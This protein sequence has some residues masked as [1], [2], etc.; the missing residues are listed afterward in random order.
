MG[1]CVLCR[2]AAEAV[3]TGVTR[4]RWGFSA[5][6]MGPIVD[7]FGP[8]RALGWFAWNMSRYER[9]LASF[10]P[11]RTHLLVTAI[12]LVNDSEY[13][14]YG[15]GYALELVY[16]RDHDQL[17]PLDEQELEQLRGRPPALIRYRLLDAVRRAGL[18]SDAQWLNR[19]IELTTIPDPRPVD[20]DDLRIVHL[21]RT[22]SML[23]ATAIAARTTPDEAH[24]AVN[25]DSAL[26]CRYH[27]LRATPTA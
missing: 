5:H 11:V 25:K 4:R 9:T 22:V 27:S 12:S 17:F 7:Q 1:S 8:L 14:S 21:V 24:D 2:S 23:N 16:L 6:L 26:K 3:L 18:H 13:F 20:H 10:G 15:H 19:T